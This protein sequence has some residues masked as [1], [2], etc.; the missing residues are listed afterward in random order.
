MRSLGEDSVRGSAQ[1]RA[2]VH[3]RERGRRADRNRA[4][5]IANVSQVERAEV[6]DRL[7]V[8]AFLGNQLRPARQRDGVRLA[9]E[10]DRVLNR[11]GF[12][13]FAEVQHV[14]GLKSQVARCRFQV[15]ACDLKL[16]TCD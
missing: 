3:V 7:H 11:C 9:Q 12:V 2:V 4:V 14:S 15:F 5:L 6:N 8:F 1:D 13:N 16:A 10:F